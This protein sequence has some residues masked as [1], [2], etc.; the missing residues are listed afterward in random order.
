MLPE[1]VYWL[2]I[3]NTFVCPLDG[4]CASAQVLAMYLA[5]RQNPTRR[6]A[7]VIAQRNEKATGSGVTAYD[8]GKF[9]D[10]LSEAESGEMFEHLAPRS[11]LGLSQP[12][13]AKPAVTAE[14]KKNLRWALGRGFLEATR[15]AGG[16][17]SA[18]SIR[19]SKA[20]AVTGS[21]P[22]VTYTMS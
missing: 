12:V 10:Q 11:A 19:L 20:V 21:G 8:S 22:T 2:V 6:N 9:R 14:E 17:S 15:L 18:S 13:P 7:A 1:D 3:G 5:P 4:E 16:L